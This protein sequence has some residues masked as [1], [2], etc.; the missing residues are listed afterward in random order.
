MTYRLRVVPSKKRRKVR[1]GK[2]GKAVYSLQFDESWLACPLVEERS[3][4]NLPR[5]VRTELE[6]ISSPVTHSKG[7]VLFVEGQKPLGVFVLRVGQVKLSASSADGKSLIVGRVEPGEVLGL[8]TA[9]SGKPN[10]LTAEALKLSQG[11]FIAREVFLQFLREHGTA[12]LRVAEILSDMYATAFEQVRYLG[13]SASAPEK[14]AR[15]L[16]DLAPGGSQNHG[17][18]KGLSLTHKEI[19]EMIGS[20]RETVT[21]IFARFRREKLIQ[22][23]SSGLRTVDRPGLES[24]LMR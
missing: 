20:S 14:L 13:L 4:H 1:Q 8:P 7:A 15:L 24:L 23:H 11:S 3:F 17:H 2:I 19:A 16:L 9:I 10:E 21:R 18:S 5:G 22:E 12:A 6:S